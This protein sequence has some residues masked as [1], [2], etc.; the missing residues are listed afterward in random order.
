MRTVT[1]RPWVCVGELARTQTAL[2]RKE[3]TCFITALLTKPWQSPILLPF[4]FWR[5]KIIVQFS[6][7]QDTR[8]V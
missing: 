2:Q 5:K 8:W 3:P 4:G 7:P 1:W 6:G